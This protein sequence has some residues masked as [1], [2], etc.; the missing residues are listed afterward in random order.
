[1]RVLSVF[2][3]R[4]LSFVLSLL[5][6]NAIAFIRKNQYFA[7]LINERERKHMK[8]LIGISASIAAYRIP[9]LV[10]QLKKRD[11]SVKTI[12][13]D[14]ATAFVAPQ[15][16]AVMSETP[17]LTDADEWHNSEGALHIELAKWCDVFLVAP[18][19]ANTLAKI[20]NGFCDN[21][22]TSS[23]RA[24]NDKPLI[25][26]P[27]MNTAMWENSLTARHIRQAAEMYRITLIQPVAKKLADG[28]CGV[29][30][31]AEDETILK[32]LEGFA[33]GKK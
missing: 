22:L 2:F 14:R 24:L 5:N 30:G 20:A 18:L 7:L 27:A 29:G 8:I 32:T 28:D 11:D 13:T 19:T 16:L 10:S 26:A 15:A 33:S 21:L 12:V 4:P 1:L 3:N 25:L 31:L 6:P 23:I 17:C 9:N